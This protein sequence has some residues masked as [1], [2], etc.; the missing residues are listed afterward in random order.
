[1]THIYSLFPRVAEQQHN[2]SFMCGNSLISKVFLNHKRYKN[3]Y[4][5]ERELT[6]K[7]AV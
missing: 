7:K 2:C 5:K 4:L 1:M 6:S 3:E